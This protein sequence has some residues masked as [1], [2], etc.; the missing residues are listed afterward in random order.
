M[1][2]LILFIALFP[3][4]CFGQQYVPYIKGEYG[5]EFKTNKFSQGVSLEYT[6]LKDIASYYNA[7]LFGYTLG[8]MYDKYGISIP[9]YYTVKVSEWNEL[10]RIGVIF[11]NNT[12]D[13]RDKKIGMDLQDIRLHGSYGFDNMFT[14]KR[15]DGRLWSIDGYVRYGKN[16]FEAGARLGIGFV[17]DKYHTKIWYNNY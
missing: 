2:Y 5:Y 17:F 13:F 7:R 1:K 4:L 3:T 14:R 6:W 8:V 9:F 11:G 12:I 16:G 15:T 10:A